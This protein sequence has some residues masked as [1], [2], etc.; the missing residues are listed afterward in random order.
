[1]MKR[2]NAKRQGRRHMLG[3][4]APRHLAAAESYFRD[5]ALAADGARELV[6]QGQCG[7]ALASLALYHQDLGA[8]YA[9]L[10]S[11]R[12][13]RTWAASNAGR[14]GDLAQTAY[15]KRCVVRS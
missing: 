8:G 5:A 9:N 12:A 7:K 2:K 13:Q 11:A 10:E 6:K 15:H 3:D 1:M 14:L 4:S